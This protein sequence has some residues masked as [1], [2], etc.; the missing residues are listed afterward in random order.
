MVQSM[1][2]AATLGAYAGC[3]VLPLARKYADERTAT[4]ISGLVGELWAGVPLVYDFSCVD[5]EVGTRNHEDCTTSRDCADRG[6][7]AQAPADLVPDM[8]DM[9][10]TLWHLASTGSAEELVVVARFRLSEIAAGLDQVAAIRHGGHGRTRP[11][12]FEAVVRECLDLVAVHRVP[13]AMRV[14]G[15]EDLYDHGVAIG[16]HIVECLEQDV[17]CRLLTRPQIDLLA[18]QITSLLAA[19]GFAVITDDETDAPGVLVEVIDDVDLSYRHVA[20]HWH[21]GVALSSRCAEAV[22]R[23][24]YAAEVLRRSGLVREVMGVS[25]L[26][27]LRAGGFDAHADEEL[28][29]HQLVVTGL[30]EPLQLEGF[31]G[32]GA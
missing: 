17:P 9:V 3:I 21:P 2:Q 23:G 12:A 4:L 24:D 25:L 7:Q 29:T 20:I 30:D 14:L 1:Q 18:L 28:G 26:Q 32:A 8:L 15:D 16:G 27:L 19:S 5:D 13:G 11:G 6:E 10:R 22:R 31:V